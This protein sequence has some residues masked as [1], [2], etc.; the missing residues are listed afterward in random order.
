[1]MRLRRASVIV[2]ISLLT[3]AATA[4]ADCAWVMWARFTERDGQPSWVPLLGAANDAE[5][6]TLVASARFTNIKENV[7]RIEVEGPG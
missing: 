5:C 4:H 2:V 6:K 7:D 3:S 1:M